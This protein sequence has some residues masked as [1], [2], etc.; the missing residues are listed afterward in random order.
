MT[1]SH[2]ECMTVTSC[3]NRATPEPQQSGASA[4]AV[5]RLCRKLIVLP[6]FLQSQPCAGLQAFFPDSAVDCAR[7]CRQP[8]SR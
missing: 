5:L 1:S 6:S 7:W 8:N 2:I 4:C 3:S